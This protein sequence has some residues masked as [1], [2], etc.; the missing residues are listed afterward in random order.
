[1]SEQTA[2]AMSVVEGVVA[3]A[4]MAACAAW[5]AIDWWLGRRWDN[6]EKETDR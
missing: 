2:L 4:V 1:M 5:V 6:Q 3:V